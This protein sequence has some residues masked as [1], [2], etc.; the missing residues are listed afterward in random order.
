MK[1]REEQFISAAQGGLA[2]SEKPK[3]SNRTTHQ[4]RRSCPLVEVAFRPG[5][6]R[7]G[8]INHRQTLKRNRAKLEAAAR[9]QRA[10]VNHRSAISSAFGRRTKSRKYSSIRLC[11]RRSLSRSRVH[12]H[13]ASYA[14]VL[15]LTAWLPTRAE[16]S[17]AGCPAAGILIGRRARRHRAS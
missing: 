2:P 6:M 4:V 16:V 9:K 14:L 1:K 5:P 15:A 10:A 7:A 13:A 12:V 11:D 8:G 3:R 17:L